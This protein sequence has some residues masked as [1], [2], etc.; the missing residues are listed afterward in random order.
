MI[1][2]G[3]SRKFA[4]F[5]YALGLLILATAPTRAQTM[6]VTSAVGSLTADSSL[7]DILDALHDRGVGL[8]DFTAEV[9]L[10]DSDARTVEPKVR[11][12]GICYQTKGDGDARLC[13]RFDTKTVAGKTFNEKLDYL[14]DNGILVDR[15]YRTKVQTTRQVLRPGQ[16][17]NLLKLGEGPFPLPIGQDKADVHKLFDAQK[18]A[19][20]TDDPAGTFHVQLKPKE[21][22]R[23]ANKF[24]QIDVWV[25]PKTNMPTFMK[26]LDANGNIEHATTLGNI[27]IN[28]G[29]KDSDFTLPPI[30]E[31]KWNLVKEAFQE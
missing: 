3:Q 19:V 5:V 9:T 13:A 14:L 20:A 1:S 7:D 29:V 10:S 15:D 28:I 30:E 24:E 25:D 27:K 12:G 6:P 26:T 8:K 16:K 22:T 21:G 4:S 2:I 17:M 31:E 11:K 18:I 23:L